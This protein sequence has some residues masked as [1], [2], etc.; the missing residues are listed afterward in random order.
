MS[1]QR[2][3]GSSIGRSFI[4]IG[5]VLPVR[6][7]NLRARSAT[8]RSSGF[9]ML[10]GMS[11]SE[12]FSISSRA[13]M[14]ANEIRHIAEASRLRSIAVECQRLLLQRLN[15]EVRDH[16]PV[17][18][19]HARAVGIENP[20]D[21]RV[22]PM[23]TPVCQRHRFRKALGFVIHTARANRVYVSP[24]GFRLRIHQRI[25]INFRCAGKQEARVL[26]LCQAKRLVGSKRTDL[27]RLNRHFQVIHGRRR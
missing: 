1:G 3:C 23:M 13:M 24:V 9:P 21:A 4:T 5:L 8:V 14:S 18:G 27:Q 17:A 6:V 12:E 19:S 2:T 26:F 25:A 11:A 10:K 16:S 7:K 15:D 22:E 20:D